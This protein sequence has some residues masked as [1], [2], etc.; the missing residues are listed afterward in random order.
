MNDSLK[1]NLKVA[2]LVGLPPLPSKLKS[3]T[4]RVPN[5]LQVWTN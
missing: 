1:Q 4:L 3:P 2:I 5:Q